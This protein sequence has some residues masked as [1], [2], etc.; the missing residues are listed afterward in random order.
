MV[1]YGQEMKHGFAH[2]LLFE[3][4][5]VEHKDKYNMSNTFGP[6]KTWNLA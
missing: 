2:M 3:D 6:F 1:L 4:W 5:L